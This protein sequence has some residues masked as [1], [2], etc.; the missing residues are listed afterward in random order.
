MVIQYGDIT[1]N[2]K[3]TKTW[4]KVDLIGTFNEPVVVMGPLS[5]NGGDPVTVRVKEVTRTSFKW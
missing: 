4:H 1:V 2:Q 3:D 5:K